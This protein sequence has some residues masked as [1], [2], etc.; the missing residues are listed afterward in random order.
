MTNPYQSPAAVLGANSQQM[1]ACV[2]CNKEIHISAP[3]CPGCGASQRKRGYKSKTIAAVTAFLLGGFGVHRFYLGQW[4]GIFYL[5]FF[6]TFIPGIISFIEFIVFLVTDRVKWDAK[7]NEGKPAAPG[8]SSTG[9]A[10]LIIIVGVFVAVAMIGILAAIALPAYQDYTLRSKVHVALTET[11]AVKFRVAEFY[12]ANDRMPYNNQELGLSEPHQIA[13]SH[14][15]YIENGELIL[16]LQDNSQL[17]DGETLV[18][19]PRLNAGDITWSCHGGS[20]KK[21][22]RPTQ[23]R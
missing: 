4:W 6:W 15:L 14:L 16:H 17:I 20:V 23:C 2:G 19:T 5:L 12:S 7:Y 18:L 22:Y 9:G 21:I 13:P 1:V 11:A 3:T 10:I 8:E